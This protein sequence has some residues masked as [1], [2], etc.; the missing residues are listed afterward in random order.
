M[1]Y[2]Q[3]K[4]LEQQL[5][6][7]KNFLN[8]YLL[9]LGLLVVACQTEKH[10]VLT[11]ENS[12]SFTEGSEFY[13]LVERSAMHDGSQDD[14]LDQ[15]PCF[16]ISFPYKVI[17]EGVEIRIASLA[18]LM[19]VLSR[20]GNGG[21]ESIE[22]VFPVAV[23]T[24]SYE[25]I[26]VSSWEELRELQESCVAEIAAN[27]AP[28]TC[29]A[30]E[31]PVKMLV[32]NTNTQETTSANLANKQQL[33]V[34]LQNKAPHEVLSFEYPVTVSFEGSSEMEVNNSMELRNA[35]RTCNN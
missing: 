16:S 24:S 25:K 9:I 13:N 18:D 20:T 5:K 15:S 7:M 21:L 8:I 1:F 32:Y 14:E 27:A 17:L 6:V 29:A 22:L 28:I 12:V 23:T 3:N 35:L 30:I 4:Q 33:Y 2:Y 10:E 11:E 34:F 31:F 19:V 26:S